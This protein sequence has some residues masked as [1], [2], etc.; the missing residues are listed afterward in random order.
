[1]IADTTRVLQIASLT[2]ARS[3]GGVLRRIRTDNVWRQCAART[4]L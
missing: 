3:P 4:A 2:R 1:M